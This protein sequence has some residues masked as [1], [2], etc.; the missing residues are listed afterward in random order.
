[1]QTSP[2]HH[3]PLV[4]F[5][6]PSPLQLLPALHLCSADSPVRD[7]IGG[8]SCWMCCGFLPW[9]LKVSRPL[10]KYCVLLC[11]PQEEAG[12]ANPAAAGSTGAST[13]E[14]RSAA[15]KLKLGPP[16]AASSAFKEAFA[17]GGLKR[18]D[19]GR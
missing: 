9:R 3:F 19:S 2:P 10:S 11:F 5:F 15:Q 1:M 6:C 14:L 18:A 12:G 7:G 17:K 13:P 16:G 4:R 8:V